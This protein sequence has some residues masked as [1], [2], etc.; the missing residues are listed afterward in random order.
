[1][2]KHA[3]KKVKKPVRAV[4]KKK[5]AVKAKVKTKVKAKVD[6]TALYTQKIKVAE[7]IRS[8]RYV[9]LDA[10]NHLIGQLRRDFVVQG[11]GLGH[12]GLSLRA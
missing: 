9:V 3:K 12:D 10:K 7:I 6:K 11:M 8:D 2:P 4:S 1:M 5:K